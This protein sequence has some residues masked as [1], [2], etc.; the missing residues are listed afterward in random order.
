M[1]I[2]YLD[3]ASTTAVCAEA[4]SASVHMMTEVYGNPSSVHKMGIEAENA[5]TT[6]RFS[7][8]K[9]LGCASGEVLFTSGGTESDNMAIIRGAELRQRF[10]RHIITSETEHAAV[11][12]AAKFLAERGFDVTYLKPTANGGISLDELESAIRPDTILVS[13]M[14]TNNETGAE[15]PVAEAS[16]L[17]KAKNPKGIFHTDA[18]QAFM[19]KKIQVSKLGVDLLS[20]SAHKIHGPKGAGALYVKG[21][22][23]LKPL[24]VGGGQE[25]GFRSGT[26][27]TP[28]IVGFGAAVEAALA[29]IEEHAEKV[30]ALRQRLLS[31][32]K[33]IDSVTVTASGGTIV[34]FSA[35]RYPAEVLIRLL[36]SRNIFVSGGSACNR[37]GESHVLKAMGLDSKLIKSSVRTSL[38]HTNDG[39]DVDALISALREILK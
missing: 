9:A 10:G 2:H 33:T 30:E 31:G 15:N 4:V 8:S 26:E 14:L 34:T 18:V 21:G 12:N 39:T 5:V 35:P 17:F 24:I 3:N 1:R 32:L 7:V 27:A 13:L 11:L 20:V 16:R 6:A 29:H 23:L 19:K 37:G 36:E 22:L 28:A 25:R 38:S